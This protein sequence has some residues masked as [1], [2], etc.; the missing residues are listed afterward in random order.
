[1]KETLR[2]VA[3]K[4][5]QTEDRDSFLVKGRGE[6]QLAIIIETMR[7]E[8]YELCVSRPEV[9]YRFQDGRKQEP[10]EHLFIDCN[11][12]FLGIVSEKLAVR[13]GRV[14]DIVHA[15]NGRIRL[16]LTIPSRGL[17]G[18]RDEFLTDTKGTGIMN[19]YLAGYED[20]RGDFPSRFTGSIVADRQGRAVA[21]ALFNLEPRG[22]IFIVPG[23][24]VYEG[25]IIGEHNRENDIN[26][27]PCKEKKLSNMRA[28]GKDESIIL[29]PVRPI[30][31]EHAMDF[32]REDEMVEVTPKSI[33][34]RKTILSAQKR[35][36]NRPSK[37]KLAAAGL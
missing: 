9:I 28:A 8:G 6:F 31:L 12:N 35:Y 18:Y 1:M 24:P 16:E 23:D 30:T 17:I 25:M 7:R 13:K 29:T 15:G 11:E 26:V 2:N 32:I 27:N 20:H 10:I 33:R 5:E 37:K 34:L 14:T 22:Q 19:A 36:L 4:V 3:I 21:Y